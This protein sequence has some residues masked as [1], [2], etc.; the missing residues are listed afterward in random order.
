MI[1]DGKPVQL[2]MKDSQKQ[3]MNPELHYRDRSETGF[4]AQNLFVPIVV[5]TRMAM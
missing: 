3:G 5:M 2:E 1:A 4:L